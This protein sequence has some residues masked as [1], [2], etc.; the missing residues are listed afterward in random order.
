MTETQAQPQFRI[1]AFLK[2]TA[3]CAL[4]LALFHWI[5]SDRFVGREDW[6][7]AVWLLVAAVVGAWSIMRP[8]RRYLRCEVCAREYSPQPFG[9]STQPS[10]L[11]PSCRI[12]Q[13]P[14]AERRHQVRIGFV[15]IT[16]AL[17]AVAVALSWLVSAFARSTFGW[18]TTLVI[19]PGIFLALF[20]L[21]VAIV[22]L[23][24]VARRWRMSRGAY[25]LGLARAC[26]GEVGR[27]A[28]LGPVAVYVYGGED[29]AP[30]LREQ[31]EICRV[32]FESLVGTSLPNDRRLRVLVFGQ[33]KAFE[34]FFRRGSLIIANHD[35]VYVPWSTRTIVLTTEVSAYRL[36][37]PDRVVRTLVGYYFLHTFR[38]WPTRFWL[39][40][41]IANVI[42][43]GGDGQERSR[44]NRKILAALSRGKSLASA[45]IFQAGSRALRGRLRDWQD[46]GN[47]AAYTQLIS[48]SWSV[49][50]FLCGALAPKERR[51]RFRDFLKDFRAKHQEEIFEGHFGFGFDRLLEDWRSWVLAQGIGDFGPTPPRIRTALLERVL[52]LI[53]DR[54]AKPIERIQAIRDIGRMGFLL[55]ADRLVDLLRAG[56]EEIVPEIV[57]TLEAISGQSH[58]ADP[59][60]WTAW[61][62]SLPE[63][64]VESTESPSEKL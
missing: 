34:G 50:E 52:P 57:W 22:R 58:G 46:F 26:S 44:L 43:Y 31:L 24:V 16:V 9:R 6:T 11:C 10:G 39:E 21:V 51:D 35:G 40:A 37:D 62:E 42:A 25:A 64:A 29:I 41:G 15:I 53:E 38:K 33:R 32:R 59:A 36:T 48:Q 30:M 28:M 60:R 3:V 7:Y 61:W 12:A 4:I 8:K 13:L 14:R 17:L 63:H 19:T 49:T 54:Q 20:V 18:H 23:Q 55:G 27:K 47:H 2:F 1:A 56:E 5:G 45:E